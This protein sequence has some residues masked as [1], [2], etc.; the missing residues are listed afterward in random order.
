MSTPKRW[1]LVGSLY[2]FR[3][4]ASWLVVMPFVAALAGAGVRDQPLGDATLFEPGGVYLVETLRLALPTVAGTFFNAASWFVIGSVLSVLIQGV[5]IHGQSQPE[6][7]LGSAFQR[8]ISSF[9]RFVL[10]GGCGFLAQTLVLVLTVLAAQAARRSIGGV[11]LAPRGDI[12]Y[13]SVLFLGLFLL[14]AISI[15]VDLARIASAASKTRGAFVCV[16]L[17]VQSFL[18]RPLTIALALVAPLSMTLALA[19]VIGFAVGALRVEQGDTWRW[20]LILALHQAVIVFACWAE[21]YWQGRAQGFMRPLLEKVAL[22]KIS[23]GPTPAEQVTAFAAADTISG[24]A[25]QLDPN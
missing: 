23:A 4:C 8:S 22:Q 1:P 14:L 7:S 17:S 12:A 20:V 18:T 21:V 3:L 10:L 5:V 15:L 16:E 25:E 2:A 13:A 11:E 19:V 6:G 24:S 9:P